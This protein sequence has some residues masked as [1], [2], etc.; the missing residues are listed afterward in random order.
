MKDVGAGVLATPI[1][2]RHGRQKKLTVPM[3]SLYSKNGINYGLERTNVNEKLGQ[4]ST[5]LYVINE[6][7]FNKSMEWRLFVTSSAVR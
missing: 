1:Q 3:E 2:N 4:V 6:Y 5:L 7:L